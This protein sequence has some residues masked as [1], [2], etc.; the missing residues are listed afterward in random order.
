VAPEITGNRKFTVKQSNQAPILFTQSL[1]GWI[2]HHKSAGVADVDTFEDP[3]RQQAYGIEGN[4]TAGLNHI[5]IVN[6]CC[7]NSYRGV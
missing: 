2:Q 4:P 1:F 7:T 3:Y 5:D 6:H